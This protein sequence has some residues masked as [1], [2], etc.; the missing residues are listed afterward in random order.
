MTF[1]ARWRT[2]RDEVTVITTATAVDELLREARAQA[3]D[4]PADV[5]IFVAAGT[6]WVELSSDTVLHQ[7]VARAAA[8]QTGAR[9]MAAA[10]GFRSSSAR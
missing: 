4:T 1:F 9:T 10:C 3:I 7:R 2:A 5:R 8:L 6:A